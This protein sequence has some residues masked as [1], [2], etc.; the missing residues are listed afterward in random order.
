MEKF[1]DIFANNHIPRH[2]PCE[3]MANIADDNDNHSRRTYFKFIDSFA[4]AHGS[5]Q[6]LIVTTVYSIGIGSVL[7]LVRSVSHRICFCFS[8]GFPA[9]L[10]HLTNETKQKDSTN[11]N[12]PIC[13]IELWLYRSLSSSRTETIGL[14]KW[15]RRCSV[16]SSMVT[17]GLIGVT[18]T[19]KSCH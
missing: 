16:G 6:I 2:T 17:C 14:P 10:N 13:T 8:S 15:F 19:S 1:L 11:I 12:R 5:L 4:K 9:S 18:I 7:G 3:I